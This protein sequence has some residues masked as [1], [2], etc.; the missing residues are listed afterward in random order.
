M[1]S[2]KTSISTLLFGTLMLQ[3]ACTLPATAYYEDYLPRALINRLSMT[4]QRTIEE[5]F[6]GKWQREVMPGV[7]ASVIEGQFV[8]KGKDRT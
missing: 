8:L 6:G 3:L 2:P 4:P 7:T 5:S 1:K